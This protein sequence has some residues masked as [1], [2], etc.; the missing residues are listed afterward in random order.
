MRHIFSV[1]RDDG[2]F[3]EVGSCDTHFCRIGI[4]RSYAVHHLA[5]RVAQYHGKRV[6][7]ESWADSEFYRPGS[8]PLVTIVTA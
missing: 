5:R 7:V 6:R 2:T 4:T 1:E 8:K 3:P